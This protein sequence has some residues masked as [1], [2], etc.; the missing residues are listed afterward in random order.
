MNHVICQ[1]GF[2]S[3]KLLDGSSNNVLYHRGLGR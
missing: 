1:C 3:A 2:N